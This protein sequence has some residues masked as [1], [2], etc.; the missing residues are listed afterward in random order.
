MSEKAPCEICGARVVDLRRG[1]C[2]ACYSR[3]VDSRPVGMGA[4]CA[5]CHDRR[6]DNLR[7]VELLGAWTPMCFNC[8]GR[9]MRLDPLPRTLEAIRDRLDRDR[10][11]RDRRLGLP[12][13]RMEPMERRGVERRT[14][15]HA[16][17][18]DLLLVELMLA[19][20]PGGEE[21]R[22]VQRV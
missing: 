10:R 17:D 15:G 8:H 5:C 22:I 20:E 16:V 13:K 19:D 12:D 2:F 7:L 3:W 6:R 1:R 18:G 9:M 4:A 11:R 14:V 21:T